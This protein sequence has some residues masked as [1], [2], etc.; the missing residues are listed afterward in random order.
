[1][2]YMDFMD[3]DA[4]CPQKAVKLNHLLTHLLITMAEAL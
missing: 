1:M 2:A 4:R 3:P